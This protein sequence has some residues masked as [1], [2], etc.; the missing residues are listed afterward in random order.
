MRFSFKAESS[1]FASQSAQTR[2]YPVSSM[3][4]RK[5]QG[6]AYRDPSPWTIAQRV[7]SVVT[8]V[9]EAA[10][11][12][13]TTH[14]AAIA[15]AVPSDE[16]ITSQ[17]FKTLSL[18]AQVPNPRSRFPRP[19]KVASGSGSGTHPRGTIYGWVCFLL[20]RLDCKTSRFVETAALTKVPS[21]VT[22]VRVVVAIASPPKIVLRLIAGVEEKTRE[23]QDS[24]RKE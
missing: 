5:L 3:K 6:R 13:V 4:A 10:A 20:L 15:Q 12:E 1:R 11:L 8:I 21:V 19:N 24:W 9:A 23:R 16:R 22:A 17:N 2:A 18:R 14:Q 7:G